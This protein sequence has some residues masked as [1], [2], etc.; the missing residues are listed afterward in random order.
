M[1]LP[2]DR[3][4][5]DG[6]SSRRS[7]EHF[8]V[9]YLKFGLERYK[10]MVELTASRRTGVHRYTFPPSENNAK[11]ILDLGHILSFGWRYYD[12]CITDVVYV[13]FIIYIHHLHNDYSARYE[14]AAITS[15]SHNQMKG[16]GAI[17]TFD[18]IKNPVIVSRV[19]ISFISDD[20]ACENAESEVPDWDF[21]KTRDEAVNAWNKELGRIQV[22]GGSIN[23]TESFYKRAVDITSSLIDIYV[24]EGYM[25]DGRSGSWNGI[26]QGGSNADMVVAETYLKKID[27][28]GKIDWELAYKALIKDAEVDPWEKGLSEGRLYLTD[29]KKYGYI[30]FPDDGKTGYANAQCSRTLEYSANDYS[31]GLVAQ[32]SNSAPL[33]HVII[34]SDTSN[35]DSTAT[36]NSSNS[37]PIYVNPYVQSVKINDKIWEKTWFRHSDISKGAIMELQMGPKPSKVWGVDDDEIEKQKD[38]EDRVMPPSMSDYK[39]N[40]EERLETPLKS[41]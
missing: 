32:E 17:L 14:N 4:R 37:G 34:N 28:S 27:V 20:Q 22:G 24:H 7:F 25:P 2:D 6:Y 38:V 13:N 35:F 33:N 16:I 30:P 9:G 3:L 1:D 8:E 31:I 11:V 23:V 29:Y 18:T 26:T 21:D 12:I 41:P 10:I 36:N 40:T 39:I 19:G 5:L 15:I